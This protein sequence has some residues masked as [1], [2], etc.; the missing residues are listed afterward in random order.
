VKVPELLLRLLEFQNQI[1][2][3]YSG[4]FELASFGHEGL[5][6][7]FDDDV[8]ASQFIQFAHNADGSLYCFWLYGGRLIDSAPIIFLGSEG[9]NNA[10]LANNLKDF[11]ALLAEGYEELG[12]PSGRLEKLETEANRKLRDWLRGEFDIT[13]PIDPEKNIA[14]AQ[15]NHPNLEKWIEE[16]QQDQ[17]NE[18]F[19]LNENCNR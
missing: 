2:D 11:F 15:A 5:I 9:Q 10:V 16:R 4:Y 1:E 18:K 19:G 14:D 17:K 6:H 8:A 7:W 3:W 13:P 12:F